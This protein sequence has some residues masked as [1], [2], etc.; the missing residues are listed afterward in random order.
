MSVAAR[1]LGMPAWIG[2]LAAP[3]AGLVLLVGL[4]LIAPTGMDGLIEYRCGVESNNPRRLVTG[5][6]AGVGCALA[7]MTLVQLL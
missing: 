4:A 2:A 1:V 7:E 3:A 5:L 6:M